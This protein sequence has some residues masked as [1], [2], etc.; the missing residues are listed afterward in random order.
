MHEWGHTSKRSDLDPT[1]DLRQI[2]R[3]DLE[4]R[5][6]IF[7]GECLAMLTATRINM[8]GLKVPELRLVNRAYEAAENRILKLQNYQMHFPQIGWLAGRGVIRAHVDIYGDAA[9]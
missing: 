6:T 7:G 9:P 4:K 2:E 1:W 8:L 5:W 3:W